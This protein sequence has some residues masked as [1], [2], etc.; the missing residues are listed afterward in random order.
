MEFKITQ[1]YIHELGKRNNQEDMIFP[2]PGTATD[3]DRLFM[4]C[5]G[6][7]GHENGEKASRIVC[8]EMSRVIL[9]YEVF[10]EKVMH[11][12]L[13]AALD[14]LDRN[15]SGEAKK[16]GTTMT[17]LMLHDKG[18]T[19]AHIG[20]SR[21]YHIR[22]SEKCIMHMTSDH[23]LVNELVKIGEMTPEEAR[24]SGQKNVITR[25]MMPR[26]DRRP[27][28]DIY[29]TDDIRKGDFFMLCSDGMLEQMEDKN[30]IFILGRKNTCDDKVEMLRTV[31][32]ENRDN[33][34]A[35]L[36]RIDEVRNN[37]R[38][39]EKT[40]VKTGGKETERSMI[41]RFISLFRR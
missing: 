32:R 37:G 20:D 19:I 17:M 14:G 9:S 26:M 7:G 23:S 40:G 13:E 25:A 29:N 35:Y 30:L 16:M 28:A 2:F 10:D 33:H 15:D 11:E 18:A 1:K 22:P 8:E 24:L 34:S 41:E 27:K 31:T 12:A 5:D 39:T 4:V 38:V 21:V 3:S 36:I 6:M